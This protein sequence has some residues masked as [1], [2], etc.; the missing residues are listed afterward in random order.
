MSTTKAKQLSNPHT[1]ACC[2]SGTTSLWLIPGRFLGKHEC[3]MG[4]VV[5]VIVAV[6]ISFEVYFLTI[7][8]PII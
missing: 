7:T 4:N 8:T 2:L 1:G 6:M 5:L 3:I